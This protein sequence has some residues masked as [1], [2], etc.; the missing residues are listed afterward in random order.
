MLC[1]P[2]PSKVRDLNKSQSD[3]TAV[4]VTWREPEYPNG[5]VQHYNVTLEDDVT[6]SVR[7]LVTQDLMATFNGLS[8]LALAIAVPSS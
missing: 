4:T 6:G 3:H 2:A 5:I 1:V 7:S 8:K